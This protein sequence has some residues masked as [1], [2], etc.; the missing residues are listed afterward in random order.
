MIERLV[1][2]KNGYTVYAGNTA[3]HSQYN[4]RLEAEKYA[5]SL[6]L[7]KPFRYFILIEPGLGYLGS[8]LRRQFPQ[9]TVITLHCSAFFADKKLGEL[10]GEPEDNSSGSS[11]NP[12]STE[13]LEAFLE[14][15]IT[16]A[17][18]SAIRLIE[19][20]P[21]VNAY[22]KACLE[23][24]GRTVEC[25]RRINAGAVT[26]RNFGRRW[27]KNAL[28]NLALFLRPVE[29]QKGTGAV[30][31]CAAGPGLEDALDRIARWKRS[32]PSLLV[33]AVSSAA[34]ALLYRGIPPD[35]VA[36]T[37]GG[38][39]ALFHLYES[40]RSYNGLP[41]GDEAILAAGLS[42]A[43]PS[44]AGTTP[45]L[46]MGDGTLWQEL[47]L[48]SRKLPFLR[49]PQRGTVSASALDLALALSTGN[50]YLAGLDLAHRDLKT[51]VR[52]HAFETLMDR[53]SC[54]F[55]P[56]YS[57][58]FEREGI[59][60]ASGSQGIY[61][62]WF[63]TYLCSFPKRIFTLG[64]GTELGIPFCPELPGGSGTEK[65]PSFR[66]RTERTGNYT[67]AQG[68][69]ILLKALDDPLMSGPLSKEL[70]ELLVPGIPAENSSFS[71]TLRNELQD[72]G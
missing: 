42:A 37:D 41:S 51:H 25:V 47:L 52:P 64:G 5:A 9:S 44:Q 14:R 31:I 33:I 6:D 22:G 32:S 3:L 67:T 53:S 58:A 13:G 18:A 50:V 24:A 43:L 23:L 35:V 2:A 30:V 59:I 48:V 11:W 19:W 62:S 72:L 56:L 20:R 4:P 40:L 38:G 21:S 36:A 71:G 27:L 15:T 12:L 69:S 34:P 1:P 70:G 57:Q 45:V 68:V 16:G 46:A 54:R 39:W 29:V 8:V 66:S 17:G 10:C 63:K 60:S 65:T 7:E 61:A 26:V 49:F 55:R 28:R